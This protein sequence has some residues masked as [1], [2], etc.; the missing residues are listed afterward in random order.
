M[1]EQNK[2]KNK[3]QITT[4]MCKLKH[5]RNNQNEPQDEAPVERPS[6]A[7]CIISPVQNR[8]N[9]NM[10]IRVSPPGPPQENSAP[11]GIFKEAF[12]LIT[13]VTKLIPN[14]YLTFST[15]PQV[16]RDEVTA[17]SLALIKRQREILGQ[18]FYTHNF[19]Y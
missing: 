7:S 4:I 15:D 17:E 5:F 19:Y 11:Q 10:G 12:G 3:D 14:N 9:P 2:Y 6:R 18:I 16:T 13:F 8:N 1:P